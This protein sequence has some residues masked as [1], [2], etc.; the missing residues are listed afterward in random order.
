MFLTNTASRRLCVET[1]PLHVHVPLNPCVC[2]LTWVFFRKR[3]F[4]QHLLW[5]LLPV[6]GQ[7]TVLVILPFGCLVVE[8]AKR[9]TWKPRIPGS[10]YLSTRETAQWEEGGSANRRNAGSWAGVFIRWGG[11]QF[12]LGRWPPARCCVQGVVSSF[13]Y[14]MLKM[15][16][17]LT[18]T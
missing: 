6:P 9:P 12:P 4:L 13:A 8:I 14:D 3:E 16:V 17:L 2:P 10:L 11:V 18:T 15:A 5:L 1:W 7:F